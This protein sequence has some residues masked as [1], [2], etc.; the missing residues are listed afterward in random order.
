MSQYTTPASTMERGMKQG[1]DKGK[2]RQRQTWEE[3][4]HAETQ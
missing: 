2:E 1:G 4:S 3:S